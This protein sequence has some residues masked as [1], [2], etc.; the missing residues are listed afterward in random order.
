MYKRQIYGNASAAS[1]RLAKGA[2]G[3]VLTAGANDISWAEIEAGVGY[4]NSSTSTVPG[5]TNTDLGNLTDDSTDAFGIAL[6]TKYDLMDPIGSLVT[7][8]LGA[9]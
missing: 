5:T 9:L 8:D 2:E 6:Q 1:A 3:T 7:L 4:Q